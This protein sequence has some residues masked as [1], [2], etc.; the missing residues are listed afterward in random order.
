MKNNVGYMKG[1]TYEP[2]TMLDILVNFLVPYNY[3]E[4]VKQ[5]PC[6]NG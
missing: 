4:N 1:V 2:N 6:G 5:Y 3:K